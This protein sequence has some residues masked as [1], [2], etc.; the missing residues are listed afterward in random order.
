MTPLDWTLVFAINGLIVAWGFALAR[1]P[2]TTYDWFLAAKGL[3]WWVVGLSLFATAVD[4]GDYV[5]VVGGAYGFGLQ[6]VAAWWIGMPLGWF[7][8]AWFVFLPIYR[9]G[10]YTNSEWLE[11]RFTPPLR[12]L[13]ALIQIQ[14]RTN[15]LGNISYSL[16]LTFSIAT[17]WGQETWVLVVVVA[18]AAGWYTAL[19]GLKSVAMTDAAQSIFIFL[20]SM[21]LWMTLWGEVGGWS[22]LESRFQAVSPELAHTML[23][24]GATKEPGVPAALVLFGWAVSLTA[25]VVVNHS[26]AMRLLAARSEWDMRIAAAVASFALAIVMWFNISLGILARAVY[27]DLTAV[28]EAFP[29]LVADYMAP[30]LLGLVVAGVLAGGISTYDSITSSLAAVFTRD[31]Y[32]RFLRKNADEAET[33]KTSRWATIVLLALS[34]GYIPF[35]GEGMVSF[36]LRLTSVFVMPLFTVYMMGALTRV[37][38]RSGVVGLAV[39][40]LYG[41]SSF[42]G[43]AQDWDLPFWWTNTWWTYLWS[44]VFPAAAMFAY[45]FVWGWEAPQP[46][47]EPVDESALP[48]WARPP[49]WAGVFFAVITALVV[50][51]W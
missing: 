49:V 34:F 40:A 42:V 7:G 26:Q 38:R 25:Y 36:Y 4:S 28:D 27:P 46:A 39:G 1:G 9:S 17:G 33:L 14:Y 51:L 24:I 11:Q 41:L 47:P 23:H 37:H 19:G 18:A 21:L 16:Y 13:G 6:N 12:L 5:A 22:G 50:A 31:I 3:P 35:F 30:G 48:W 15:V 10:C 45:S 32:G 44:V 20:A 29:R 2:Q 8:V 43:E